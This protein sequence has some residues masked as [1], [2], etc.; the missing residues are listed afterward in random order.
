MRCGWGLVAGSSLRQQLH[1]GD[2]LGSNWKLPCSG[3]S[4]RGRLK[5]LG[6]VTTKPTL[7]AGSVHIA[8]SQ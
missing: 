6:A 4:Q 2:T 5:I 7:N 8:W 3:I 1:G